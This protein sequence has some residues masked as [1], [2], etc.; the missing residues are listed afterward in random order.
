MG[1]W[2]SRAWNGL[3][4]SFSF[5]SHLIQIQIRSYTNTLFTH[6]ILS[7]CKEDRGTC[8]RPAT[9]GQVLCV[10]AANIFIMH[11][12]SCTVQWLPT[13]QSAHLLL[14]KPTSSTWSLTPWCLPTRSWRTN[15]PRLKSSDHQ[16]DHIFHAMTIMMIKMT[17]G[18]QGFLCSAYTGPKC[19][20]RS[21]I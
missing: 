1:Q 6:P 2:A 14:L 10:G 18:K 5:K 16:N 17:F 9:V 15:L 8:G 20:L 19:A 7:R 21:K 13:V 12:H 4:Y 11:L 3:L